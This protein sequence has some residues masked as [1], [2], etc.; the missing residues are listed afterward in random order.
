V[1]TDCAGIGGWGFNTED[2]E[3]GARRGP[4][5]AAEDAAT[6]GAGEERPASGGPY[7]GGDVVGE[8]FGGRMRFWL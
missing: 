4:S 2:T 7:N 5:F 1:Y 6:A 8:H 3:I